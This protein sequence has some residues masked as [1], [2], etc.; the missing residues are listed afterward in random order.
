MSA[1]V[2]RPII[3]MSRV[4]EHGRIRFGVKGTKYPKALDTFRFTSPD[5]TA[6][7]QIAEIYGGTPSPWSDRSA[8]IQ[9]QYEVITETNDIRVWLPPD[10]VSCWYEA[11]TAGGC[12]RRCDGNTV[13]L[14]DD[15]SSYPCICIA[16]G[17][18]LCK[19]KTRFN[20]VLPDI[21]FG[22][23]WRGESGSWDA[24]EEMLTMMT[25]IDK[26]RSMGQPFLICR[27]ILQDMKKTK[28]GETH[29]WKYPKLIPQDSM[30]SIVTGATNFTALIQSNDGNV[31]P[32]ELV[33][34]AESDDFTEPDDAIDVLEIDKEQSWSTLAEAVSD[35]QVREHLEKKNG[36]W[37][38]KKI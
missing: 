8:R 38:L 25:L 3:E 29:R 15:D 4:Q 35:G 13:R 19:P 27:L 12:Q 28:Q 24:M 36:K 22:G 32:R 11:W 21:D 1:P 34:V 7:E 30:Q 18:R 33:A 23:V 20:F 17:E 26:V 9:N 14:L 5:R 16:K 2:V 10:A 6:I 37:V 31:R